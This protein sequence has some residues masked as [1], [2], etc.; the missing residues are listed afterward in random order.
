MAI[1]NCELVKKVAEY[2]NAMDYGANPCSCDYNELLWQH[3]R[4]FMCN[5]ENPLPCDSIDCPEVQEEDCDISIGLGGLYVVNCYQE[6][7][8]IT[9]IP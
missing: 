5:P 2:F 4:Y 6:P 3:M 8:I 1:V 9:E 7:L